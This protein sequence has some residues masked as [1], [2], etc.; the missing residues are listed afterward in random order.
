MRAANQA[1]FHFN[2]KHEKNQ[3]TVFECN[4]AWLVY[5]YLV[6]VASEKETRRKMY[7][8]EQKTQIKKKR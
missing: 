6:L 8:R 4:T 3:L 1:S 7:C 5:V 2:E